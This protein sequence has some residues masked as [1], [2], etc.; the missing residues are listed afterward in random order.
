MN[1]PPVGN[2]CGIGGDLLG[3]VKHAFTVPEMPGGR[4]DEALDVGT[5]ELAMMRRVKVG[6][7]AP[8]FKAET[9]DGKSLGLDDL[10]GKYVL[11]D[12]WATW[13]G[14]CLAETPHL[15][16]AYDAFGKDGRVAMVGMSLDQA[17]AAPKAMPERTA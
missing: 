15:K 6:D 2:Q 14:P 1:E 16:A 3:S 10:K 4:S 8:G 9:L 11:L 5:L 17:R 12:F 13:C 7:T